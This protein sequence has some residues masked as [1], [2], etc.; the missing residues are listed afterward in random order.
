MLLGVVRVPQ[1]GRDPELFPRHQP[2]LDGLLD[3]HA[4]LGFVAVVARAVQVAVAL[5][6]RGCDRNGRNGRNG[7]HGRNWCDIL[8]P[9]G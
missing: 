9:A 5:P 6:D 2:L 1:L 3:S 8:V 7:R 4:H